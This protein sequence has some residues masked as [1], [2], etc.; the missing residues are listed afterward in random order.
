MPDVYRSK[1][2]LTNVPPQALVMY[3]S[4]AR[5]QQHFE[6]FLVEGLKLENYSLLAIPGGVHAMVLMDYLPK[7]NWAGWRW[8]KFLVD[9][10]SPP[11]IVLIGHED[12]R[13]YK[14]LFP[15]HHQTPQEHITGDLRRARQVL[16]ERF[17]KVRVDLYYAHLD[18]QGHVLFE[19]V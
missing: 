12:C 1:S 17:P 2:E 6:E 10:D 11:R 7:F 3:C 5:Y 8:T 4:A 18:P 15:V 13:W 9:A 16:A 14:H 19:A